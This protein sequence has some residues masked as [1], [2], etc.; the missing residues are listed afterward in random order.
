MDDFTSF[1][2][3]QACLDALVAPDDRGQFVDPVP[4]SS[5]LT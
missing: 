1:D 4:F 2:K 5:A 3:G